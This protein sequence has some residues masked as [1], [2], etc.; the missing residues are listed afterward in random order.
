MNRQILLID[1]D[2]VINFIHTRVV[3]STYPNI[4][5]IVFE[6]GLK[7]FEYI[8]N[9]PKYSYLV[10]LDLNMPVMNG[11]EFL[12]AIAIESLNVKIQLHI[13]TS[14]LDSADKIRANQNK[15]VRSYITKPLTAIQ[16]KTLSTS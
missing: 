12:E 13:L 5:I 8:R 9:N 4:S 10:F 14:S 7:A 15:M 6:N 2:P 16:L 1:D 11:W 3:Q